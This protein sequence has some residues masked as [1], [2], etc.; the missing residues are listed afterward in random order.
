[1][2]VIRLTVQPMAEPKPALRYLLL[3][4]LSEM[5]PGNPMP[6]YLQAFLKEPRFFIDLAS[7]DQQSQL[8]TMPLRD[9]PAQDL[10]N[11]G[12]AALRQ[13]DWAARLDKP[14]WQILLK[15]KTDGF[16]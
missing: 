13:L 5:N 8:A 11:Y 10:L 2:T 7:S 15:A 3:P 4:E 14:D 6:S 1:E 16:N 12:G 9:L